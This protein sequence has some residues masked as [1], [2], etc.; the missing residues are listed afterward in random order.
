[1]TTAPCLSFPSCTTGDDTWVGVKV[2]PVSTRGALE[3]CLTGASPCQDCRGHLS[4]PPDLR[5]PQGRESPAG[6]T[7]PPLEP[8]LMISAAYLGP[9]AP[10]PKLLIKGFLPPSL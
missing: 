10:D 4:L 9:P 6:N 2:T 8:G 5:V 3:L 7:L 1:M